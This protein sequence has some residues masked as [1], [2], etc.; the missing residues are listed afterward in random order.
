[1]PL[2][3]INALVPAIAPRTAPVRLPWAIGELLS[4]QVIGA[5]SEN[6]TR[7]RIGD[8]IVTARTDIALPPGQELKL[9]V[10]AHTPTIVL[11]LESAAQHATAAMERGLARSLPRQGSA[12]ETLQL[13]RT[14]TPHQHGPVMPSGTPGTPVGAPD[15]STALDAHSAATALL[16]AVPERTALLEPQNLRSAI[17]RCAAP[18]E[19]LLQHSVTTRQSPV[20]TLALPRALHQLTVALKATT[21]LP[22]GWQPPIAPPGTSPNPTG[23]DV[24]PR[25]AAAPTAAPDSVQ[26]FVNPIEHEPPV[27]LPRLRELAD[28]ALARLQSQQIQ[29]ALQLAAPGTPLVAELLVRDGDRVDLWRFEIVPER[30]CANGSCAEDAGVS[31]TVRMLIGESASF[32]ARLTVRSGA[33]HIQLGSHDPAMTTTIGLHLHELEQRM[34]SQGIALASLFVGQLPHAATRPPLLRNLVDE[35]I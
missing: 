10:A 14:F 9:R 28:G 35:S 22:A 31:I 11:R 13:L 16:R 12:A 3:S 7:L 8:R 2:D 18:P 6:S 34:R 21:E 5:G 33:L 19:A 1:M 25:G 32:D 17:E 26:P 20:E 30:D 15:T 29:N 24:R 27:E 23:T 4:A